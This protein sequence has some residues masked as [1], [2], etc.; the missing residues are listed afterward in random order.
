MIQKVSCI[1]SV[2]LLFAGF[3]LTFSVPLRA[4]SN[5]EF[6]VNG[7]TIAIDTLVP[8]SGDGA[9]IAQ[10]DLAYES[11]SQR[12]ALVVFGGGTLTLENGA[13]VTVQNSNN[14]TAF[15]RIGYGSAGTLVIKDGASLEVGSA[16]RYANVQIGQGSGVAGSVLQEGGSFTAIGSFNV[17]VNG[18]TGTYT[19]TDGTLTFAHAGPTAANR[20][21][22]VSIGFNN[23][24]SSVGTSTGNFN[25]EGGVV[26]LSAVQ[27]AVGGEAGTAIGFIIGNRSMDA[28]T[29]YGGGTAGA[30]NGHVTQTGGIFRVGAGANL[31]LSGYGNGV[32]D[33]N[34]GTLEIGGGS[35]QAK[36]GNHPQYTYDFNLGGGT[37][38]VIGSNLS[39]SVDADLIGGTTSVIDTNGLDAT[40]SGNL[41]AEGL[42]Q[43]DFGGSALVKTGLGTLTFSGASRVLDTFAV[44]GGDIRQTAGATSAVEFMVGS[45]SG[46]EAGYVMDG[47]TL[48][49]NPSTR[50]DNVTTVA[51]S[52]RVGDFGGTGTF[53]QNAG[54]VTVADN[55]ALNI[56]NQG[57]S[58]IYNLNGGSLV[59]GNGLHVVGRSDTVKPASQGVLN[60]DGGNLTVRNNGSLFLGNNVSNPNTGFSSTLNQTGGVLHFDAGTKFYLS[61]Y[62]SGTY[63]LS[64]GTL[65]I[66]GASLKSTYNGQGDGGTFNWGGGTIKVIGSSLVT[67]VLAALIDGTISTVNT[68][69]FNATFLGTITGPG[70][71]AKTGLG[72]LTLSGTNTFGAL[73]VQQGSATNGSG[74]TTVGILGIGADGAVGAYSLTGGAVN[75]VSAS[76]DHGELTVG[77]GAGGSGTLTITGGQLNVGDADSYGRV[78]VGAYDGSGTVTQSGG[79]VNTSGP[80]HIGN[81]G[82]FGTYT[83]TAGTLNVGRYPA[84]DDSNALILGRSR[85]GQQVNVSKGYLNIGGSGALVLNTNTPLL[86]GGDAGST[87]SLSEGYVNQTGGVVTVNS[88][89][90]LGSR[91]YGEYNLSG[92]TLEIG[93]ATG[94]VSTSGNYAF[95]FGGG[96]IKVVN[97][98][99]MTGVRA[100]LVD[101]TVSTINTNGKN[102][103]FSNG[104]AGG[105]GFAKTGAGALVLNGMTD[106]QA[107]STVTGVLKVGA[108]AGKTGTL[109]LTDDVT[110]TVTDAVGRLQVGV[111]GGTG[112]ANLTNGASFT[113]NDAAA[114]SGWGTLD[115]GRGAGSTGVFNHSA[116]TVDVSGG[117]LQIGYSGATGT[118]N[119]EGSA[120]LTLGDASS[121]FVG[122]GTNADGLLT[123]ADNA[124]LTSDSQVF[125]GAGAGATGTITQTGG[126]ATFT[127]PIVAFGTDSDETTQNPGTGIYNLEGGSLVFDGVAQGVRVG[128]STYGGAGEFNQSGGTVTVTNTTL[129]V[130]SQG[131]Y[132][133]SGGI[134]EIGGNNL[135]GSGAY[136]LGGGTILVSGSA[137]STGLNATLTTGKI[138]TV[139]TNNLGATFSGSLTGDGGLTKTGLGVLRLT[140]ASDYLGATTVTTGTLR[141]DGVLENTAVTVAFG[142]TLGGHG[143]AATV[144]ILDGGRIELGD[145]VGGFTVTNDLTLGDSSYTLLR[146]SSASVYDHFDIGGDFHAGGTLEIE[147]TGGFSPLSGASF[148]LFDADSFSGGFETVLLPELSGGLEWNRDAFAS[149]G[150]LTVE[151]SAIPE[152]ATWAALAG[153]VALAVAWQRRRSSPARLR[154]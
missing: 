58:G 98:D 14:L 63:R 146:I 5:G 10:G 13:D 81:R 64:G 111:D 113:I 118:Y 103:T 53:T 124:V 38:K 85:V 65:E 131:T 51:G 35:L 74:T 2:P 76:P 34:G 116:G 56:G 44:T 104:F 128:D 8:L 39:T 66:G 137:L 20:T 15:L 114:T 135:T 127:G 123:I 91:G 1:R 18:G 25:I 71:L 50:A 19:I 83:L 4:Q 43:I 59:L 112:T 68:D 75:V 27:P 138:L 90:D 148:A 67:D 31:F 110:V 21:S 89:I 115:V 17:G 122:S 145:A 48:V 24:T 72:A 101:G 86:I 151:T 107:A 82:G 36:Y 88:W 84:A 62:T 119:L 42:H 141:L 109:N 60:I 37:I 95:N 150:V 117:A 69:G 77:G 121:I 97:S 130:G 33:L 96:T 136:R 106:I 99:L 87:A 16:T 93:G 108:G 153:A 142:A 147:F 45:G 54:T 32:Y 30:G 41:E 46:S 49:I 132:T 40:W 154:E 78:F 143:T 7:T 126:S 11:D 139:N 129:R 105:G 29:V 70:A 61:A 149:T 12:N 134:L 55:G 125:V 9:T 102:A 100:H 144:H 140:G 80:F 120:V 57:G 73:A 94:L 6:T 152:P 23:A 47:G 22:L 79:T 133:Q 52:F 28:L 3:L 92:G 26:E